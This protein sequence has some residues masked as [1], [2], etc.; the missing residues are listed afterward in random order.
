MARSP[1]ARALSNTVDL[2][3]FAPVQDPDAGVAAEPYG[4]AFATSVA[5]SVQPDAPVRYADQS[6]G[7][8]VEQ[9]GYHVFFD[10]AADY[11]LQADD[12]I[13]WTDDA[14]TERSLYV[15]GTVSEAGKGGTFT[16]H[17]EERT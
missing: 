15:L 12:K 10:D 6:I 9:T 13:I 16:V 3:R 8:I 14:G 2:Y 17:A 7:R 1:S 5:C 11:A 4:T